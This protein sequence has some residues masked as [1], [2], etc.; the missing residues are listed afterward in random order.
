MINGV[1]MQIT[2]LALTSL[3]ADQ[4]T[5][6]QWERVNAWTNAV[7]SSAFKHVLS[8]SFEE[9]KVVVR[10]YLI[11]HEIPKAFFDAGLKTSHVEVTV[12]CSDV[13]EDVFWAPT[14]SG[15]KTFSLESMG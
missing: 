11:Q 6:A 8:P 9:G 4:L 5:K 15:N 2:R 3:A 13:K 1:V 7:Q 14:G 12:C 10:N